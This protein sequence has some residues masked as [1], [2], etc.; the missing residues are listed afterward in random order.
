MAT[1]VMDG[2]ST[3]LD[4]VCF[5]SRSSGGSGSLAWGGRSRAMLGWDFYRMGRQELH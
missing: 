1:S 2:L 4:A 3:Q 5:L